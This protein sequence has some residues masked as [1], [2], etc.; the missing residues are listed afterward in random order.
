MSVDVTA[1]YAMLQYI[2]SMKDT[3]ICIML[4][5][6]YKTVIYLKVNQ[7][8]TKGFFMLKKG[9]KDVLYSKALDFVYL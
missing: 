4:I 3:R 2:L 9:N 1:H 7:Y 8:K 5:V 6:L